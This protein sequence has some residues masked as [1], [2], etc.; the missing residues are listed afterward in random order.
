MRVSN[1]PSINFFVFQSPLMTKVAI[2]AVTPESEQTETYEF[3]SDQIGQNRFSV[4]S[5]GLAPD[6]PM[7]DY[8]QTI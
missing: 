4:A 1:S 6:W 5:R 3:F 8:I 7:F 2:D